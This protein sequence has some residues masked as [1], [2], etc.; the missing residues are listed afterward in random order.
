MVTAE[1]LTRLM[2]TPR[3]KALRLCKVAGLSGVLIIG[4]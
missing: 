4:P 2:Q 1:A 3:C